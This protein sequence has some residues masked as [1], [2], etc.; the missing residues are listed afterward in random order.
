LSFSTFNFRPSSIAVLERLGFETPTPIQTAALPVVLEGKD[1]IAQA[2]TGSGKTLAYGLPLIERCDAT[3]RNVQ[4]IVLAPTRELASQI[5]DVLTPFARAADLGIAVLYGGVG[6]GAQLEALEKG[7]QILVGT[8]GRVLDHMSRGSLSLR[9]VRMFVLDEADQMLDKGFALDVEKIIRA[10]PASR[11]T[12]LFSATTPAWVR[13]VSKR[14]LNEPVF[15]Q[16][17]AP[18]ADPEIEHEVVEVWDGNKLP[19]LVKLLDRSAD[20][21]TLVFCRTRRG[22]VNLA[23][24]LQHLGYAAEALQGDMGQLAR[25]R[26]IKRFREGRLPIVVA[27]N[28]AARG[29][30][31]LTISDVI[32]YDLPET[33]ELFV[34][35][36]GRT[37][38]MGR[39]GRATTLIASADLQMMQ[40]IERQLG[41]RLPRVTMAQIE[42]RPVAPH[43][44]LPQAPIVPEATETTPVTSETKRPARRRYRSG[45]RPAPAIAAAG[46]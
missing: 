44:T 20:G 3:S 46:I 8:P 2:Q 32:N 19:V 23:R 31:I 17:N 39:S 35:R 33:G 38:R 21:A 13:D 28:V 4:A 9:S 15:V 30:D 27:T 34:H 5:A 22:V 40:T 12:A 36:V 18:Q 41:R 10:T 1:V 14:Y 16:V 6:F 26:I 42:S 24:R 7:A 25:E 11:Q 29:L 43:V 45:R 37:G